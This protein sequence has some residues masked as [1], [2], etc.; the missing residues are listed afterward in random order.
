MSYQYFGPIANTEK[1]WAEI[2]RI[3]ESG[4]AVRFSVENQFKDVK[5]LEMDDGDLVAFRMQNVRSK[6]V[7]W[8]SA[9]YTITAVD[10]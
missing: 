10:I 6:F 5:S 4:K 3:I 1:R 2:K 9:L 8:K 7:C